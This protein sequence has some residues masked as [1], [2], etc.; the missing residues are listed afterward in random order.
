MAPRKIGSIYVVPLR[1]SG[2]AFFQHIGFDETQMGSEVICV[3]KQHYPSDNGVMLSEVIRG[4]VHFHAHTT[5]YFGLKL[6]LW[7]KVGLEIPQSG[8]EQ[9]RFRTSRDYGNP[10]I[11]RSS[12]WELWDCRPAPS[13]C[14]RPTSE[15]S[16]R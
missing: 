16:S 14:R 8:V 10:A 12:E 4:E 6:K 5:I 13:F 7:K 3:F 2:F 9:L 1:S 15:E 11:R